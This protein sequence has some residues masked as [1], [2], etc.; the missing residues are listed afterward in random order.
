MLRAMVNV[1]Q[2]GAKGEVRVEQPNR[3]ERSVARRTAEARA[4]IPDLELSLEV[5]MEPVLAL[6]GDRSGMVFALIVWSC[7]LALRDVPRANGAYR[8]GQFELYSRVNIGITLA[9]E[10]TYAIATVFDADVKTPDELNEMISSLSKRA[11][12]DELASPELSGAT[13]TVLD[14]GALGL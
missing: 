12:A 3:A 5:D 10:S 8:D 14:G 9:T 7:A 2:T 11:L 4:T 13:F 1:E 6:A